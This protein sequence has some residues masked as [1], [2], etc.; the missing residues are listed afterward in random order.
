MRDIRNNTEEMELQE[1]EICKYTEILL[2]LTVCGR[3]LV[4]IG[5]DATT[6]DTLGVQKDTFWDTPRDSLNDIPRRNRIIVESGM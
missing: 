2:D 5:A 3:E 6:T 4:A 1:L